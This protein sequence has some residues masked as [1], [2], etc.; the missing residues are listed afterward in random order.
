MLANRPPMPNSQHGRAK[1]LSRRAAG[2]VALALAALAVLLI[3][4][5]GDS[6]TAWKAPAA[7][8]VYVSYVD[9]PND[10]RG[11]ANFERFKEAL[12]HLDAGRKS[13]WTLDFMQVVVGATPGIEDAMRDLV[14]TRPK[15]I[16]ATSDD[17]LQ[18]AKRAT[19][20]IPILFM[21]YTDPVA[22]GEVLSIAAPGVNRTGFTFHVPMLQKAMEILFDAYPASTHVGVLVD[23]LTAR[24]PHHE[25]EIQEARTAL[26]LQIDTFV[27]DNKQQLAD[28]L[29]R[30]D[31]EFI[32][33]WYVPAGAALWY[34][35]D[36][37]IRAMAGT[38]RPVLYD[39]TAFVR[40]G[41]LMAYE[42]RLVDPLRVWASQLLLILDGVDVASI[43][44]ERPS[45]FELSLN[46]GAISRDECLRP[47][48]AILRRVHTLVPAG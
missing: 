9:D 14:R 38:R 44:V 32:D 21:S 2:L 27:V 11:R 15:V 18:A 45:E 42:A 25:R 48:K 1:G 16:I 17:V 19:A 37:V 43:P 41:G 10:G 6:S 35:R 23:S 39:R 46:L 7:R 8:I 47:S 3:N 26:P 30:K 20:D 4:H 40:D 28:V 13:A 12:S 29:A 36:A 31:A 5:S 33:A 34:D 24:Q 22:A